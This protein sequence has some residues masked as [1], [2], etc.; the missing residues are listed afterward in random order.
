MANSE[1]DEYVQIEISLEEIDGL[2]MPDDYTGTH[3]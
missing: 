1:S 3:F 2:I